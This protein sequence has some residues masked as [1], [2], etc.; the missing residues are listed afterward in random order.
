MPLYLVVF[1]GCTQIFMIGIEELHRYGMSR[2]SKKSYLI[3]KIGRLRRTQKAIA[4][5]SNYHD[6]MRSK[7]ICKH[8]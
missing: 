5:I 8:P 4:K 1:D 2:Y 7:R 3:N 6:K